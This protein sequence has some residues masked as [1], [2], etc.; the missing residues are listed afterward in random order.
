MG[1]D[2][3]NYTL[4]VVVYVERCKYP[5][6]TTGKDYAGLQNISLNSNTITVETPFDLE[7][8]QSF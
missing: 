6:P 8:L 7:L 5:I 2:Y 4:S 3:S 1:V